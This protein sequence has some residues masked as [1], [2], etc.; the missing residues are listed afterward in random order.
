MNLCKNC[1]ATL[2]GP[3]CP[4]CGQKDVDLERPFLELAREIIKETFDVD[5]RAWRT[6]KMLFAQPGGLTSEFL[7]GKRK[8]YTP[9][10]RLYIFISVSFFV[11]MAWAASRGLLLDQAQSVE[12][13]AAR[14][15]NFMSDD[16]PRLMFLLMPVFALILKALFRKRLYFDHLI[17]SVHLHS[18]AYV[19]LAVMLPFEG[20]ANRNVPALILQ[21]ALLIYMVAYLVISLRRVYV[22][23][24]IGAAARALAVLFAYMIVVSGLIETTSTFLIISD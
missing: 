23:T 2:D 22:T 4:V 16:L 21:T 6:L 12:T 18:A 1:D 24:W 17:F 11:L 9:P 8:T 19:I 14:Q 15:A 10:L 3:F 5:G 7:A 13:D 20:V